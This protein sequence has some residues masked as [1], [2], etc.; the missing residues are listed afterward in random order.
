MCKKIKTTCVRDRRD[1][2]KEIDGGREG[3]R[4]GPLSVCKRERERE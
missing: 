2:V 3:G 4:E 1:C